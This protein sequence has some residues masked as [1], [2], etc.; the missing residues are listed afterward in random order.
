MGG[1]GVTERADVSV[2]VA[3]CDAIDHLHTAAGVG[4]RGLWTGGQPIAQP[5]LTIEPGV[6]ENLKEGETVNKNLEPWRTQL[7][8]S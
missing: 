7:A 3:L 2:T 8:P 1:C 4:T 5:T 6:K